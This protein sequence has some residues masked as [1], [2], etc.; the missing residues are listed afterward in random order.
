MAKLD[1][2]EIGERLAELDGWELRDGKLYR[3]FHF[4]NFVKA[5]GWMTS[6][7]LKAEAMNH[8]P[9]WKNVYNRVEVELITHDA[10]GVT[11][12]DFKLAR[13]MNNLAS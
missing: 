4:S 12:R 10:D 6:V 8:H 1:A 7:A 5:F 3:E 11:D 13:A 9:D 2:A